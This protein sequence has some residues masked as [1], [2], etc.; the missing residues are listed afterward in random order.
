MLKKRKTKAE[1]TENNKE[2][3]DYLINISVRTLT[4]KNIEQ[5]NKEAKE[6]EKLYQSLSNKKPEDLWKND[7]DKFKV[8]YKKFLDKLEKDEKD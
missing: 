7:L 1:E 5:L 6:A 8:E 4:D 3:F 2:S